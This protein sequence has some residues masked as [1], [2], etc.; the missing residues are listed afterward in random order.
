[1]RIHLR[2]FVCVLCLVTAGC[3]EEPVQEH[4]HLT[5]LGGGAA[6]L[7]TVQEVAAPWQAGSNPAL[8]ERL[9]DARSELASGWDR[10]RPLYDDLDPAAERYSMELVDRPPSP[11]DLRRGGVVVR[12]CG[13]LPRGRG[14]VCPPDHRWIPLRT[15]ALPRGRNPRLRRQKAG[16][17]G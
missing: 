11:D 8:A 16:N 3:F 5:M 2:S 15:P 9:D 12:A 1:M 10:W 14:P 6:V 13:T 17:R 7:T 4:V